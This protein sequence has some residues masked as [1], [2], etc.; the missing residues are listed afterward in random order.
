MPRKALKA[1]LTKRQSRIQKKFAP[2][3]HEGPKHAL[4]LKGNKCSQDM[5]ELMRELYRFTQPYSTLLSRKNQ[6][7]PFDDASSIEFLCEK[8]H[9]PLFAMFSQSKKRPDNLVMGRTFNNE[10]L[11]MYEFAV[12]NFQP[13]TSNEHTKLLGFKPAFVFLGEEWENDPTL[14]KIQ[15]LFLDFFQGIRLDKIVLLGIDH[16]ISVS[17]QGDRIRFRPFSISYLP[18]STSTSILPRP[19]QEAAK[20]SFDLVLRRHQLPSPGVW[21]V[22]TRLPDHLRPKKVKNISRTTLGEKMGR[23]HMTRQNL[24]AMNVKKMKALRRVDQFESSEGNEEEKEETRPK[25]KQRR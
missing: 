9:C 10:V 25:K 23:I 13:A 14:L 5:T 6:I 2:K 3:V 18:T 21:R 15:N 11:D 12:E 20:P 4:F 8:N 7:H 19:L 22:A 1:G 24:D 16:I 17:V